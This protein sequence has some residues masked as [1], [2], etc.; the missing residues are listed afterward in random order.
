[1]IYQD[2]RL[3]ST[4]P[5]HMYSTHLIILW[6]FLI[7]L[8]SSWLCF[9]F[10]KFACKIQIQGF[11]FAF[12]INLTIPVGISIMILLCGLREEDVCAFHNF[13]P[14]YLFFKIP[15]VHLMET[16][17]R[18]D[19]AWIWLLWLFSQTW[20]TKHIW[21][22]KNDRN[23]STEKLFVAPLYSSLLID[24][25]IAMNRRREDQEIYIKKMVST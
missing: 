14:D 25:C 17:V 21:S 12:P 10:S 24:Q 11:S 4:T 8:I 18:E 23:A 3:P 22:P 13:I 19:Y 9:V 6:V 7:H 2:I 20:I 5:T 15:P 16:Y 1:M